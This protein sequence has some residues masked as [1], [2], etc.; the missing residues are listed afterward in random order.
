MAFAPRW[1][2]AWRYLSV[3]LTACALVLVLWF[4]SVDFF[5]GRTA[6]WTW[7]ANL[8][9]AAIAGYGLW[10]VFDVIRG[11]AIQAL[12]RSV[13]WTMENAAMLTSADPAVRRKREGR[14]EAWVEESQSWRRAI[15]YW[16]VVASCVAVLCAWIARPTP[17]K[18]RYEFRQRDTPYRIYSCDKQT[19]EVATAY[20]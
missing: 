15:T 8:G 17:S 2:P 14:A 10:A 20:P 18:M 9:M 3:R 12:T 6:A 13:A 16:L 11:R 5:W 1:F 19:G 4:V 7:T